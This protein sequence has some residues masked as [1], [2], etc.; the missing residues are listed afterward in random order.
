LVDG[1]ANYIAHR[2][3]TSDGGY[4]SKS[5]YI[6]VEMAEGEDL[7]NN[8]PAGFMG[9]PMPKYGCD[10]VVS[11]GYNVEYKNTLKAKKQYFGFSDLAGVESDIFAYKGAEIYTNGG[12]L[13]PNKTTKGF[14][15]DALLS[16]GS[17]TVEID[18]ISG[19]SFDCVSSASVSSHKYIP[20][21]VKNSVFLTNSIC[22]VA[23]RH[24]CIASNALIT[25]S[26]NVRANFAVAASSANDWIGAS[27]SFNNAI[28][29]KSI[30]VSIICPFV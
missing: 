8:V 27:P 26:Y 6:V 7:R 11:A 16:S 20:R 24:G 23:K 5:K 28:E 13:D 25:E 10:N 2:I 29:H 15:M 4:I 30:F 1:D 14:H 17:T 21:L 3:G 9:Y 22:T 18:G 12:E 19:Y